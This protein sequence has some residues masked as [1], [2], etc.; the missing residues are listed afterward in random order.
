MNEP[1]DPLEAELSAIRPL[2][3]S[4]DLRR[5][6][7]E[8]LAAVE[9]CDDAQPVRNRRLWRRG[10]AVG[11][12]AAGIAVVVLRPFGNRVGP[13]PDGPPVLPV[14]TARASS[15]SMLV[16]YERAF[17]HSA[18]EF[19]A[20]LERD[21][22]AGGESLFVPVSRHVFTSFDPKLQALLGED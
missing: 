20:L 14:A 13:P 3:P 19:D 15:G 18:D 6:I 10:L 12:I 5:R 4:P 21:A 16:V 22:A 11:V 1:L 2:D 7:G 8:R 9:R 17:A